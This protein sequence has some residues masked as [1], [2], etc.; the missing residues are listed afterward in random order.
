VARKLPENQSDQYQFWEFAQ[1]PSLF[2]ALPRLAQRPYA[3]PIT[4]A[5][6]AIA[7]QA[8]RKRHIVDSPHY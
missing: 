7:A 1:S 3:E 4:D 5:G 8:L 2:N 6:L